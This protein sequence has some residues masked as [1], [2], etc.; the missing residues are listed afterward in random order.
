[1]NGNPA[2]SRRAGSLSAARY[3]SNTGFA[4][5]E[6]QDQGEAQ[7][8]FAHFRAGLEQ[9]VG[10]MPDGFGRIDPQESAQGDGSENMIIGEEELG[11]IVG[12]ADGIEAAEGLESRQP[13]RE[14]GRGKQRLQ[15]GKGGRGGGMKLDRAFDEPPALGVGFGQEAILEH[16]EKGTDLPFADETGQRGQPH[17]LVI[18][19][20]VVRRDGLWGRYGSHDKDFTTTPRPWTVAGKGLYNHGIRI[21]NT[22]RRP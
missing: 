12:Q 18:G 11:K 16:R 9:H 15:T 10:D 2:I 17:G 3:R 19:R 13:H 8:G 20:Q 1:M 4:L 7:S 21:K 14:G 5:G 6:R 22:R